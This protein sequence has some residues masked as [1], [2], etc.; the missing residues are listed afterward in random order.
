MGAML[1]GISFVQRLGYVDEFFISF[2]FFFGD[3]IPCCDLSLE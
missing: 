2:F 1:E 3:M